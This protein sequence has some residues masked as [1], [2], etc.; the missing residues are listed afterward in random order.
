[1]LVIFETAVN[2]ASAEKFFSEKKGVL[3]AKE[4]QNTSEIEKLRAIKK[5]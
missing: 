2:A 5:C 3:C 4:L 1:M